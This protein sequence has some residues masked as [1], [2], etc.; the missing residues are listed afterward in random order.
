MPHQWTFPGGGGEWL[1]HADEL[2]FPVDWCVRVRS[3]P[4]AEAQSKVRRKHRDLLGQVEEYDGEITGAPPQLA[5]AIGAI[6]SERAAL[7]ANPTEPELQAT[8]LLAIAA[9]D[10]PTMEGRAGA[11]RPP[12]GRSP[13]RTWRRGRSGRAP[14]GPCSSPRSTAWPARPAAR[15]ACCAPCS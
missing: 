14:S 7:A 8:I 12:C 3:V 13:P 6:G 2:D 9:P 11:R 4:N 5:D 1:Y 10:L 15:W